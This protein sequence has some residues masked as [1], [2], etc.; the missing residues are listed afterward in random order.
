MLVLSFYLT[1]GFRAAILS[2]NSF[3]GSAIVII[4][5]AMIGKRHIDV[6]KTLRSIPLGSMVQFVL[7]PPVRGM[8]QISSRSTAKKVNIDMFFIIV[9]KI[10]TI[11]NFR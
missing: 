2:F 8:N 1:Q 4:I 3:T 5:L 9:E 6:A 11:F 7:Q 10:A